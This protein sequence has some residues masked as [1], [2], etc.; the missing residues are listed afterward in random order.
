M[1]TELP[2]EQLK[3]P[4]RIIETWLSL[5]TPAFGAACGSDSDDQSVDDGDL[6]DTD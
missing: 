5:V 3:Q 4:L 2:N 1:R 6:D